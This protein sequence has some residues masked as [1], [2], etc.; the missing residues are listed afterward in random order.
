MCCGVPHRLR[1]VPYSRHSGR[2]YCLQAR[3]QVRSRLRPSS[4]FSTS[5][6]HLLTLG[7]LCRMAAQRLRA[8]F[9]AQRSL[10]REAWKYKSPSSA[11]LLRVHLHAWAHYRFRPVCALPCTVQGPVLLSTPLLSW[12]I[13]YLFHHLCLPSSPLL[14]LQLQPEAHI[15]GRRELGCL[16]PVRDRSPA[17]LAGHQA[18]CRLERLQKGRC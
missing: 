17:F 2:I 12:V 11:W 5:V 9:G 13:A 8:I 1:G 3:A 14:L 4:R 7:C 18:T 6:P 10:W 15:T 16:R